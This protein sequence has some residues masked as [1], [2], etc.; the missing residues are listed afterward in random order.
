MMKRLF[1]FLLSLVVLS[2]FSFANFAD[3]LD[4]T[5]NTGTQDVVVTLANANALSAVYSVNVTWE[6]L[7]FTYDFSASKV[8]WDTESHQ[9]TGNSS[10]SG[11]SKTTATISVTNDSN[12]A[13]NVSVSK[14][15]QTETY[16]VSSSFGNKTSF[17]L[18]S[19]EGYVNA[20]GPSDTFT[21]TISGTPTVTTKSS[22]VQSKVTI[23]IS[24]N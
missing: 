1:C 11:W 6:S 10:A 4:D 21:L 9:Y 2:I 8:V 14:T 13:V 15:D 24:T 18:P 22:F 23:T 20:T 5:T 19:A 16:G 17:S 7:N 12:K 3:V